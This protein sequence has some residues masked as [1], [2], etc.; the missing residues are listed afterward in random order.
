MK[1]TV[2]C[3]I[4]LFVLVNSIACLVAETP[5]Q[6]QISQP[7]QSIANRNPTEAPLRATIA[8]LPSPVEM[9]PPPTQPAPAEISIDP[10]LKTELEDLRSQ[11]NDLGEFSGFDENA[12]PELVYFFNAD[13]LDERLIAMPSLHYLQKAGNRYETSYQH[14]FLNMGSAQKSFQYTIEVPDN[15]AARF[16]DVM[17]YPQPDRILMRSPVVVQYDITLPGRS[18]N[19]LMPAAYRKSIPN[20]K[21][22]IIQKMMEDVI[23]DP[24]GHL[25]RMAYPTAKK[26]C[27]IEAGGDSDRCFLNLVEKFREVI[28]A[29]EQGDVCALIGEAS[30]HTLCNVLV[31]QNPSDC[32]VMVQADVCRGY[33]TVNQCSGL[34]GKA[35]DDCLIEKSVTN[36]AYIGCLIIEDGDA[37]NE[38]MARVTGK[39]QYCND[40]RSTARKEKCL[41]LFQK[42]QVAQPAQPANP[43][44]P[45]G[46][47][48]TNVEGYKL[49][50]DFTAK[51][52]EELKSCNTRMC[53][54]KSYTNCAT[55]CQGVGGH[56]DGSLFSDYF[57][58][59]HSAYLPL[60]NDIASALLESQKKCDN[61]LIASDYG[62]NKRFDRYAACVKDFNDKGWAA[63]DEAYLV[64]CQAWCGEQGKNGKPE[65]TPPRC[66]CK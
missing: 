63:L 15:F 13:R 51:V 22:V 2:R 48:N 14:S 43:A 3:L 7:T 59:L 65:G 8:V 36:K 41:A 24:R 4:V 47:V 57:I 56:F 62:D 16:E 33:L 39:D 53:Q 30:Y 29:D 64:T 18:S 11:L 23:L 10:G 37:E 32:D 42:P 1:K 40:I 58:H 45:P 27:F 50:A 28:G 61:E 38:C 66:A 5:Q 25:L 46:P 34:A 31:S 55:W 20:Q 52:Y 54:P 26:R 60:A 9:N 21:T 44:A 12:L 35:Y 19:A 49:W 17:F 6:V